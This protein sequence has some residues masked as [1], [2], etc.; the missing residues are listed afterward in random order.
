MK[1][2]IADLHR[3]RETAVTEQGVLFARVLED[4]DHPEVVGPLLHRVIE[5]AL[6]YQE[7][8]QAIAVA[9]DARNNA[10][11]WMKPFLK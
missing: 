6:K 1:Q 3:Q 9:T 5:N 10:P 4:C 7:L 8:C 2:S 11:F